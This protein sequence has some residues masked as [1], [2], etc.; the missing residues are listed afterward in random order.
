MIKKKKKIESNSL[1]PIKVNIENF[2]IKIIAG[3]N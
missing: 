2:Q 3:K 1:S